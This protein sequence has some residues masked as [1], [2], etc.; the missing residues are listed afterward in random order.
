MN[1]PLP[2][3]AVKRGDYVRLK[4]SE[5]APVWVRGDY[6]RTTK[7]YTL[8]A[9]GDIGRTIQRKGSVLVFVDFTF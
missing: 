8:E 1:R 2:I 4:E 3:S 6:D 9:W 7:S 5:T